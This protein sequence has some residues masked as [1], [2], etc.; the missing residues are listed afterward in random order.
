MVLEIALLLVEGAA[1]VVD[2]VLV[3]VISDVHLLFA[4]GN[5]SFALIEVAD[6]FVRVPGWVVFGDPMWVS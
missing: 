1:I 4:V 2:P 3:V 6:P 5:M